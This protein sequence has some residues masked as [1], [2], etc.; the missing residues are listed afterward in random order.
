MLLGNLQ[1]YISKDS[2]NVIGK[3]SVRYLKGHIQCNWEI[4]R[5]NYNVIGKSSERYLQGHIQC[6]WEIF[7][8]IS[9]GTHTM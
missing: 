2:Y 8:E 4:F 9:S 5:D 7:R 3:S 6:N 1:R